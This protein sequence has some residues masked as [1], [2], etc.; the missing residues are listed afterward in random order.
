MKLISYKEIAKLAWP[1][2]L[3][4][5]IMLVNGI[6]DLGFISPLGTE[7]IAAVAVSNV[8]CVTLMN[9][10][11][12]FRLG[13]TVLVAKAAK[14]QQAASILNTALFLAAVLGLIIILTAPFISPA[15]F[16]HI[17]NPAVAC[18]GTGYL[19]YWLYV[20]A[21]SFTL[22]TLV[23]FYRGLGDTFTPL[24]VGIMLCLVNA[25][26]DYL[27]I[28]GHAGLP[29]LGAKGAALATLTANSIGTIIL[30]YLLFCRSSLIKY[31]DFQQPILPFIKE[32]LILAL[33]VG[34]STGLTNLALLIFMG[35]ISTLGAA[36]LAVHQ[37][38]MQIF[39]FAYLPGMG[40]LITAS[41]LVPQLIGS[42]KDHL[43]QGTVTRICKVSLGTILLLSG[44]IYLS[45]P[46]I[47][48]FF[49]PADLSVAKEA[50][51]TIRLVCLSQLSCAVYMVL[52]GALTGK[53]DTAFLVYEGLVSAYVIFLPLAYFLSIT[54]G[55]GVFGGYLAFLVWCFSDSL[56]LTI[57]FYSFH[58]HFA[59]K[60]N[61]L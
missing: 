10:F 26:L 28:Y 38:T 25:G 57:R 44:V 8:I 4:Q 46:A 2:T 47:S 18:H 52:R 20:L 34:M 14:P 19:K 31:L 43:I 21:V 48:A 32:Y 61:K 55:Y 58:A 40:F 36:E 56:A 60:K 41:I 54:S 11:E 37:I 53:R 42:K 24:Y 33:H 5:G 51:K 22:N 13:T 12:G 23:G 45:A 3:S 29:V 27:F 7:A 16:K 6:V 30:F 50:V 15:V 1:V 17:S 59:A 9:F 49:S 35:I 39:L